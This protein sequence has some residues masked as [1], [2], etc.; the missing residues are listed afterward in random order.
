M[1]YNIPKIQNGKTMLNT[2]HYLDLSSWQ[3][4]L[5]LLGT[6]LGTAVSATLSWRNTLGTELKMR[7]SSLRAMH[8][9]AATLF[10]K[11]KVSDSEKYASDN[12]NLAE[13]SDT[14]TSGMET[15]I[16]LFGVAPMVMGCLLCLF[17]NVPPLIWIPVAFFLVSLLEQAYE[18]PFS[19]LDT[20]VIEEKYGFN[21]TTRKMFFLDKAKEILVE[22][23]I[24]IP[25]SM[26]A[27]YLLYRF[28]EPDLLT[29]SVAIAVMAA[30]R[31]VMDLVGI[32]VV[33]PIF[34]KFT[35]LKR[36]SLRKKLEDLLRRNGM[37]AGQISVMD[38][39]RRSSK[40][41]AFVCGL[42]RTKKIVLFDGLIEKFGEDEIVSIVAHEVGHAK[43]GH[44]A[45][46]TAISIASSAIPLSVAF[47]LMNDLSLYRAFGYWFVT[48]ENLSQFRFVGFGLSAGLVGA[49]SWLLF[50]PSSWISRKMEYAADAFAARSNGKEPLRTALLK[51][52]SDNLSNIAPDRL[53]EA[54]NYSHPSIL[55]RLEALGRIPDKDERWDNSGRKPPRKG[56]PGRKPGRRS[57]RRRNP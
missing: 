36:G 3:A 7:I 42:G 12:K 23:A 57:R 9:L 55:P 2:T 18:T 10:T 54:W 50:P 21:R 44:L 29:F 40:T 38:S 25:T 41:N 53:Y 48:P 22:G 1:W 11:K 27:A 35:P 47:L 49:F 24:S 46:S 13:F 37:R 17:P 5:F 56:N 31:P 8:P 15:L 32:Y 52:S 14:V 19:Y 28:G 51:L 16:L 34:N 33:M 43:L 26:A 6:F 4:I 30:F 45:I 39:S 20:F